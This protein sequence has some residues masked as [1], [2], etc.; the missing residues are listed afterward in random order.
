MTRCVNSS[1]GVALA[2]KRESG[3]I[4]NGLD[5]QST[6]ISQRLLGKTAF[7]PHG[8]DAASQKQ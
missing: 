6:L 8:S 2:G 7:F 1:S 4:L 3:E 5:R